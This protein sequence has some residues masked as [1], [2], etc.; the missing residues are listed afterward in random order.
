MALPLSQT[1]AEALLETI[2]LYAHA[3]ADKH[4]Q[5]DQGSGPGVLGA[6]RLYSQRRKALCELLGLPEEKRLIFQPTGLLHRGRAGQPIKILD[7]TV[8]PFVA[9]E[10]PDGARFLISKGEVAECSD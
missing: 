8:E 9:V 7:F 1:E 2:D 5:E 10:F 3:F 6:Q 4:W